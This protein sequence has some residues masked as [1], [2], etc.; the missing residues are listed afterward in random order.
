[1]KKKYTTPTTEATAYQT[2]TLMAGSPITQGADTELA[3]KKT[4]T[5]TTTSGTGKSKGFNAWETWD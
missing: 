2:E 5:T 1:M 4:E 3:G